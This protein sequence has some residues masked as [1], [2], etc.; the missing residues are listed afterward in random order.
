MV[1]AEIDRN[2]IVISTLRGI[3]GDGHFLRGRSHVN[4][5]RHVAI[6]NHRVDFE[7]NVPL[8]EWRFGSLLHRVGLR[9]ITATPGNDVGDL[10]VSDAARKALIQMSM[11]GENGIRPQPGILAGL[12]DIIR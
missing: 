1:L 4:G 12:I 10:L 8:S 9:V 7:R 11:T 5:Y 3:E 2:V 6:F